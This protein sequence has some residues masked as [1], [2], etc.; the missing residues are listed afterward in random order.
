[1]LIDEL[2]KYK[3]ILILGYGIEG[4]ATHEFLKKNM[5]EAE[6]GIADAKDGE[7]YLNK[8]KDYDLVIKSP[9]ISKKFLTQKYTTATNIFFANAKAPIIGI[10]GTK[11][12]STTTSLIYEMFKEGGYDARL[13]GNIGKPMI[14]ALSQPV[15]RKTIYVLELS[16]YQLDDLQHSPHKSLFIN[17]FPEHLDYHGSFEE[18]KKAKANIGRFMTEK[19]DFVYNAKYKELVEIAKSIKAKPV[20]VVD[21]LPFEP[22][23]A[24]LGKH[25][26]ENIKAAYTVA[27]LMDVSDEDII[28]AVK[29]FKPLPHRLEFVGNFHGIDFYDDAISTTPE[30][31]IQ[32]LE[33]IPNID[34]IFL[35]GTDRGY[36]FSS[37]A[38]KLISSE[39]RN[40]VLFPDSGTKIKE[41]IEVN[42]Q[43]LNVKCSFNFFETR[44]MKE[45]V[46]FAYKNTDVG[47]VCLLSC[48]SPS[49]SVWKNFEEKGDLFKKYVMELD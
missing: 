49:Y 18:Y 1:M 20:K 16:S 15:S 23:T 22:K 17:I 10:T 42:C 9:G 12:K 26:I 14:D 13:L 8:Q 24:L 34:T 2:K 48:A 7:N 5:P 25:N 37:L 33:A 31:T 29:N 40:I 6:I 32:A 21:E 36:D 39:V 11:G 41:I 46:K 38:G 35:G 47:K 44:D 3:K 19:D 4:K 30:S 43:M 45:A 27:K 28:R